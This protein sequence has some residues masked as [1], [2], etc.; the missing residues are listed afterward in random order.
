[1]SVN[2]QSISCSFLFGDLEVRDA[3]YLVRCGCKL[4]NHQT[5][6]HKKTFQRAT[7]AFPTHLLLDRRFQSGPS[8]RFAAGST[9][10]FCLTRSTK[11]PKV[12]ILAE[13][14][15]RDCLQLPNVRSPKIHPLILRQPRA[16]NRPRACSGDSTSTMPGACHLDL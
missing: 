4:S 13:R 5:Q 12:T 6:K 1:M 9:S 7:A 11:R 16:H 8:R 10:H 2:G 15:T 3:R 14:S